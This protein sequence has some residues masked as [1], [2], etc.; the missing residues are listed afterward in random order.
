MHSSPSRVDFTGIL[1]SPSLF[2]RALIFA[3]FWASISADGFL[4][5]FFTNCLPLPFLPFPL[6]FPLFL[7]LFF[8]SALDF[9]TNCL[10]LPFLPFPLLFPLFLPLFFL[11]ALDF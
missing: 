3:K 5:G 10:P 1:L 4:L 7:P 8:L 9:F 6:L 11:S 2:K